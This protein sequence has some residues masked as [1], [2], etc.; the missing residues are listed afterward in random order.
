MPDAMS[1]ARTGPAPTRAGMVFIPGET[2][3]MGAENFY[4]E[5]RPVHRVRVDGFWIDRTPVTNAEF[6]RFVEATGYRTYAEI[7][8]RAEDYPGAPAEMLQPGSLVFT[9]P[10]GPVPMQMQHWWRFVLGADWRHPFGPDSSLDGLDEHP[11]VHVALCDVEAYAAWAGKRLPTEAEWELAARCG[12]KQTDYAWG[13]ELMPGGKPMANFWQGRFPYEN[14]VEDGYERT[15]PVGA[16]PPNAFGL[17]DMIGNTWEWTQDWYRPRHP[18]DAQKACCVPENPRGAAEDASYDAHAPG[19]RTPR[20]V[21]KGG[22]H[23][24]APNYCQRYRPA[25]RFPHPVDTSTSHVGFRC[26]A[27]A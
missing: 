20:K 11:V 23:L 9:Q 14:L 24:C 2:F 19:L 12:D 7:P 22:S 8:P 10:D 1:E 26:V 17:V 3:R 4:P 13:D 5:E 6:R 25:A 27:D 21:L 16:F 18:E 15:S